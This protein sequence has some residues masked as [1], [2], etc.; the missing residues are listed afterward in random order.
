MIW[1]AVCQSWHREGSHAVTTGTAA[2]R[3]MAYQFAQENDIQVFSMAKKSAAWYWMDGFLR[4]HPEFSV[5]KPEALLSYASHEHEQT[6][7]SNMV[8]RI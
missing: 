6:S 4:R 2:V 1:Q 5:K 8:C 3:N 7:D